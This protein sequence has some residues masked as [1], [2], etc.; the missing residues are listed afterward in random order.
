MLQQ[1]LRAVEDKL[2]VTSRIPANSGHPLHQGT[3]RETFIKEFLQGH[4]SRR[5]EIGSGEIIDANSQPGE[6]RNQLDVV[7]YKPEY[8][9]IEFGREIY[10]FLVE[11][12]VATIEVKSTI[13]KDSLKTAVQVAN[14]IKTLRKQNT[15]GAFT[16]YQPPSVL[17]YLIAYAGPSSIETVYGWLAEIHEDLGIELP[18]LQNSNRIKTIN[19]SI[20]S[21]VILGLGSIFFD[22]APVSFISDPVRSQVPNGHWVVIPSQNENLVQ[23]FLHLTQAVSG[24]SMQSFNPV[25]Y[26]QR[27][28]ASAT[29][30]P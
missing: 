8:P 25:P 18:V 16:G 19:P 9:R 10:A 23:F 6:M 14:R 28:R 4:L 3:P 24:S 27:M 13:T 21:I 11:S 22:N 29:L 15:G 17:T 12:V 5:V 20:D 2:L 7:I 26:L 30:R 1:H